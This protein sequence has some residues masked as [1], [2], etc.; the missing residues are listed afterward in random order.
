VRGSNLHAAAVWWTGSL[1]GPDAA[2][3]DSSVLEARERLE[4]NGWNQALKEP[5]L[6]AAGR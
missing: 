4:R 6:L 2:G 5:E 1:F 3:G